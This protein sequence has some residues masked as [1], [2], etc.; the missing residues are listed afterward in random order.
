VVAA[1]SVVPNGEYEA[2]YIYAG[3][4]VSQ[5]RAIESDARYF[6]RTI[7]VVQ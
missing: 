6:K 1:G 4:P 5:V 3:A 7:G 2:G